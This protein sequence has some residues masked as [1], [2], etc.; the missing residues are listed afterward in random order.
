MADGIAFT[1][2]PS[3][4]CVRRERCHAGLLSAWRDLNPQCPLP[5]R[6]S[7]VDRSTSLEK[8]KKYPDGVALCSGCSPGKVEAVSC[9]EG[10]ICPQ[11]PVGWILSGDFASM[12][13]LI[14]YHVK[15]NAAMCQKAQIQSVLI[16][17]TLCKFKSV[18]ALQKGQFCPEKE[19]Q[20]VS[21]PQ[22][23]HKF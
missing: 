19:D 10:F 9:S 14:L 22:G 20:V 6:C 3:S 8:V 21:G 11:Q 23:Q 16:R 5:K 17:K 18:R 1:Q 15:T 2:Q 12:T 4:T 13:W 7:D